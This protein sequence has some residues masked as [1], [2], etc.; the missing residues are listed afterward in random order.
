MKKT[1]VFLVASLLQMQN[2]RHILVC[3]TIKPTKRHISHELFKCYKYCIYKK[4][5]H[6]FIYWCISNRHQLLW[7]G[8]SMMPTPFFLLIFP[9]WNKNIKI[10]HIVNAAKINHSS[11]HQI[12]PLINKFWRC[13][14]IHRLIHLKCF[15]GFLCFEF[16][17]ERPIQW[18]NYL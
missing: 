1:P 3:R 7:D 13:Q 11:L 16:D 8:F 17:K 5:I 12:P 2:K 14:K 18:K 15:I 4:K 6:L 10:P 9:L